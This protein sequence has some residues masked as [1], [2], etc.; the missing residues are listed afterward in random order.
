MAACCMRCVAGETT[1]KNLT[2]RW[3]ARALRHCRCRAW[4]ICCVCK[5]SRHS[6][7]CCR[8][9]SGCVWE[10]RV[11]DVRGSQPPLLDASAAIHAIH[12]CKSM[13]RL[14]FSLALESA[15]EELRVAAW[16]S[17]WKQPASSSQER[18]KSRGTT[19]AAATSDST[20][21]PPALTPYSQNT[22]LTNKEC[23]NQ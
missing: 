8:R 18:L 22:T 1:L 5:N 12:D 15:V 7:G 10:G 4:G 16:E 23:G 14:H 21:M 2:S 20:L 13:G 3:S 9:W 6:N 17:I 11:T 19:D